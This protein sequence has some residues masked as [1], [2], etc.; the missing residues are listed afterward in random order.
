MNKNTDENPDL[1]MYFKF[2]IKIHQTK[3]IRLLSNF[4]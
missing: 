4:F 3:R 2:L 1:A